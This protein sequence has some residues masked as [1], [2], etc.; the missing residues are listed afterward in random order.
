MK[1]LVNGKCVGKLDKRFK[2]GMWTDGSSDSRVRKSKSY[3][4]AKRNKKFAN[5]KAE[6]RKTAILVIVLALVTGF[7]YIRLA[8]I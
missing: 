2:E 1:I 4:R 8:G 5:F 7:I 3:A 6:L